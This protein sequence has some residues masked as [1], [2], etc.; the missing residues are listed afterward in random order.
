MPRRSKSSTSDPFA[1]KVFGG[2][3][4]ILTIAVTVFFI[5]YMHV[6]AQIPIM[7][8]SC[9]IAIVVFE[10]LWSAMGELG[11]G[12]AIALV[13]KWPILLLLLGALGL[14]AMRVI[15]P[16]YYDAHMEE[17]KARQAAREPK[18]HLFVSKKKGK[19]EVMSFSDAKRRCEELGSTWYLSTDE[20]LL[21]RLS[22]ISQAKKRFSLATTNI[23]FWTSRVLDESNAAVVKA[24]PDEDN[25][26]VVRWTVE[27]H[28]TAVSQNSAMCIRK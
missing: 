1:K 19:F 16:E 13:R 12:I 22:K 5:Q 28:S 11:Q 14:G 23:T 9:V 10:K 2:L 25:S 8:T 15:S 3:F 6:L 17:Q 18:V 20:E 7:A 27:N 21:A 24:I 26:G 4:L